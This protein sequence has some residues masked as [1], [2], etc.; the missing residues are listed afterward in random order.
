MV[1]GSVALG[2]LVPQRPRSWQLSD[3][4]VYIVS[5]RVNV[6]MNIVILIMEQPIY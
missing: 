6:T 3:G 4:D 5:G 2:T 1:S